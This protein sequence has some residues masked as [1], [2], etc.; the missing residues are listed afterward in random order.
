M[1]ST[2]AVDDATW[3]RAVGATGLLRAFNDALV[4]ESS[5]RYVTP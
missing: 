2:E 4:I 3:R 5:H 1:T